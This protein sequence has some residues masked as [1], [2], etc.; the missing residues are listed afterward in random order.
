MTDG[1]ESTDGTD[2]PALAAVTEW[3]ERALGGTVIATERL[4]RWRLGWFLTL[5][6]D[7]EITELY[8]RGARGP[9]FPSPYDLGHE[10]RVHALLEDHG[11]PVP[12][13]YGIVDH[14]GTQIMVMDR[15]R[16]SQGLEAEPDHGTRQRI[17]LDWVELATRMHLI[18]L[19]D[20]AR[21]G[22]DLPAT[23]DEVVWSG[24][25]AR[26]EQHHLTAGGPPDPVIDFLRS[27][28]WRNRPRHR[29]RPAFV[30]WD[31]A[32]FLHER[33]S[34]TALIDFE[35]AHVGDPY[36]DL[37]PLRTR[38]TLEPFGDLT[39]A[40]THYAAL[41]GEPIEWDVLRWF[42]VAQLT[43]TLMLQRPVMLWPDAD[44][45]LVTHIVW[46]VESARYA[47]D[48]L[49]ELLGASLETVEPVAA[50]ASPHA[51][52]HHH[53]VTSLHRDARDEAAS[54]DPF[55]RWQSRRH[56]RLARHLQRVDEVGTAV[57]AAELD[58]ASS[59]VGRKL[60]STG[61]ADRTLAELVALE[62]PHRDE[63]ML[64]YLNRRMQR[65]SMTLGPPDALLTQHVPLQ[66]L[67]DR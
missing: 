25:I 22:F 1:T 7:G 34:I 37:A 65:Q 67:P 50:A 60:A 16:G 19:D 10:A 47:L 56:Y 9:D 52:S 33:G 3:V 27:W 18:G 24:A 13:V 20:L 14:D 54:S 44:S 43:A 28:L 41:T 6:R 63:Q 8:A 59:V 12:H 30:T 64:H 61:D 11:F 62:D 23:P 40:F 49:A 46:Y 2:D 4:A 5:D 36:M 66:T 21:R 57:T 55:R 32:Q 45:D 31:S 15:S 29:H 35:L 58:D 48:I 26:L 51:V 17:M 38:D 42:E 39:A 53:L